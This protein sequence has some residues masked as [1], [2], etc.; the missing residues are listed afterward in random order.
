MNT[1]ISIFRIYSSGFGSRRHCFN[2]RR[3]RA[4]RSAPGEAEATGRDFTRRNRANHDLRNAAYR[5]NRRSASRTDL[6]LGRS[7]KAES[8]LNSHRSG[9]PEPAGGLPLANPLVRKTAISLDV[10]S[11]NFR[12]RK[13]AFAA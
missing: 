12:I 6:R 13:C 3:L 1:V 9:A 8:D 7:W 11:P 4:D 5:P 2:D 10:A